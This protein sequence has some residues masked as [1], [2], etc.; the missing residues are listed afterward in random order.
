[1]KRLGISVLVGLFPLVTACNSGVSQQ[2]GIGESPSAASGQAAT[3]VNVIRLNQYGYAPRALKRITVVSDRDTPIDWMVKDATGATVA[4]GVSVPFGA[5]RASG[6]ALHRVDISDLVERGQYTL[7]V[8][9]SDDRTVIIESGLFKP[10]FIDALRFFHFHRMGEAIHAEH[11]T[12]PQHERDAIHPGDSALPCL[13]NWCGENVRLNV[14]NS[15][16]DAGDFGAYGVNMAISAWTLLNAYEFSAVDYGAES[17]NIPESG[18]EVPDILDEV[19][20]GSTFMAGLLPPSGQL[21]SHKIHNVQWSGFEGIL[22]K[23]NAMPRHAQ[24][25]STA[26]TLAVARNAAH[27]ARVFLPFDE[28]YARQQW[29]VA[30]DAWQRAE[31]HPDELYSG[32]TPDDVGGGDYDDGHIED[33]RYAAAVELWI[34]ATALEPSLT[35]QF[36][37]KARLSPSFLSFDADGAQQWQQVSGSGSLSLWLHRDSVGLSMEEASLLQNRIAATA[38]HALDTLD[39]SGYPMVYNP[40]LNSEDTTWPW[41]SNSFVL[42]RLMVVAY[43]HK[44]TQDRRY[45]T[46]LHQGMDYLLGNNPMN[47]SY[48]TGYGEIYTE[49]LH[50]RIAFPLL[51]DSGVAFPPGWVAGGPLT[52]WP[53]CDKATPETGAPAKRYGPPGT[54]TDAWCSKE[55]AINWNSPLVWVTAY[56][57]EHPLN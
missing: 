40:S 19:R 37:Q 2:Q 20:F 6:E 34:T 39:Q 26:A 22:S 52:G 53:G 28:D 33:D 57:S 32:E 42:N 15:W 3:P 49:D 55:V 51:R 4:Q 11:L 12:Y 17:L 31:S 14:K 18:D 50:D 48:I 36:A 16:Y 1:M 45:L 41:G 23:E 54:A 21:A 5:D 56:L 27:L 25:P 8:E 30:L 38:G 7:S 10:L 43:A 13:D 47:L 29:S 24:P 35:E 44:I 46:A 9:G